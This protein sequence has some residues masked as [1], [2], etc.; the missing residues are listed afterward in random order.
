MDEETALTHQALP[1]FPPGHSDAV[2]WRSLDEA[3]C[4]AAGGQERAG[5]LAFAW[6]PDW[7]MRTVSHAF[8]VVAGRWYGGYVLGYRS[9]YPEYWEEREGRKGR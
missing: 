4:P 3:G 8:G 1:H 6:G 9:S 5:S 7:L 2:Q